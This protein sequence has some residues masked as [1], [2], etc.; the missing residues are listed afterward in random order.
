MVLLAK[1]ERRRRRVGKAR[2][3]VVGQ[4]ERQP[5]LQPILDGRTN[6]TRGVTSGRVHMGLF[7]VRMGPSEP[8]HSVLFGNVLEI[9]VR[10]AVGGGGGGGRAQQPLKACS[11]SAC[12]AHIALLLFFFT[13]P[14]SLPPILPSSY[15][16]RVAMASPHLSPPGTRRM[17]KQPLLQPPPPPSPGGSSQAL[18]D[19]LDRQDLDDDDDDPLLEIDSTFMR[20]PTSDVKILAGR[21]VF[22]CVLPACFPL[23]PDVVPRT[24]RDRQ[25]G[26]FLFLLLPSL[27]RT[28]FTRA[29]SVVLRFSSDF[30]RSIIE[31]DWAESQP[32]KESDSIIFPVPSSSSNHPAAQPSFRPTSIA[33]GTRPASAFSP[34][35]FGSSPDNSGNAHLPPPANEWEDRGDSLDLTLAEDLADRSKEVRVRRGTGRAYISI[36]LPS[37][38]A[39]PFHDFCA[40]PS[41]VSFCSSRVVAAGRRMGKLTRLRTCSTVHHVYPHLHLQTSWKNVEANVNFATKVRLLYFDP[42]CATSPHLAF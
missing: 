30:F 5:L 1:P 32:S 22:W 27:S 41:F 34:S 26:R 25:T 29:H 36:T 8:K 42:S 12:L 39:A 15:I 19:D 2:S 10:Q 3:V 7:G 40:Y 14:A 18:D 31:G 23:L 21:N 6:G 20:E 16:A 11:V 24:E 38:E 17:S 9:G 33:E 28:V 35:D 4:G 13:R 37:N